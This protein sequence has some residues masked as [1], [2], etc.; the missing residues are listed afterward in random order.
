[1][2]G[3][4]ADDQGG[5]SGLHVL[6]VDTDDDGRLGGRDG[7]TRLALIPRVSNSR[8]LTEIQTRMKEEESAREVQ[9]TARA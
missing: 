6:R 1:M 4:S 3:E 8:A 9:R 7:N 5:V 2:V